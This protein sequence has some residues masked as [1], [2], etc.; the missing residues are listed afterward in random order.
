MLAAK[1]YPSLVRQLGD[2]FTQRYAGKPSIF[3]TGILLCRPET[4]FASSQVLPNIEYLD[5]VS[6]DYVDLF[7]VGYNAHPFSGPKPP[8]IVCQSTDSWWTFSS[9]DFITF[10]R[11][12]EADYEADRVRWRYSGN[13][14]LLMMNAIYDYDAKRAELG[15]ETVMTI[16]VEE[17]L[18]DE[19]FSSFTNLVVEFSELLRD[20]DDRDPVYALS[21]RV[22]GRLA[23]GAV[24]NLFLDLLPFK[25]GEAAAKASH[26]AVKHGSSP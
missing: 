1:N 2:A 4:P 3:A 17:A 14:D 7:A 13:C 25:L 18:K 8:D 11:A 9:E 5:R 26:F 20:R 22:G 10:Q 15:F 24:W 12:L 6:A 23:K 16:D 21:D 19:A